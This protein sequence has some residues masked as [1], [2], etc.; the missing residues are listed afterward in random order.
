M[1]SLW[2]FFKQIKLFQLCCPNISLVILLCADAAGLNQLCDGGD[3]EE[4]A[5]DEGG[6]G[7][8]RIFKDLRIYCDQNEGGEEREDIYFSQVFTIIIKVEKDNLM[9]RCDNCEQVAINFSFLLSIHVNPCY[10]T[11]DY[12]SFHLSTY[13]NPCYSHFI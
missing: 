11:A 13:V 1:A 8:L 2:I 7:F 5:V 10:P 6:E 4:D 9:D 12:F 3:Q